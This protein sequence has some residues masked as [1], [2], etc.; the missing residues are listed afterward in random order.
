[1]NSNEVRDKG[2]EEVLAGFPQDQVTLLM[3]FHRKNGGL[4]R[5]VKFRYFFENIRMENTNDVQIQEYANKFSVIMLQLLLDEKLLIQETINF[6]ENNFEE[7]IMH[8]VSGSDQKELRA[9][10]KYLDISKYFKTI[11]G[12]PTAKNILV[13]DIIKLNNY[14]KQTC[15]LIGDSINDFEAADINGI[16]FIGYG[17]NKNVLV[18]SNFDSFF[19]N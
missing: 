9:I 3:D 14:N 16:D 10:C 12:S 18:K 19:N 7:Y 1:M 8:I 2:F 15:V 17:N 6:V 4:S 5:Y 13:R 11:E